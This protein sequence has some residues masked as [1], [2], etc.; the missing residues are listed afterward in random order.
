[1][2][3]EGELVVLGSQ[4]E[5][6]ALG[7]AFESGVLEQLFIQQR[8]VEVLAQALHQLAALHFDRLL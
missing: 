3:G 7:Q 6:F 8:S 4:Q 1:M 2:L 5:Q